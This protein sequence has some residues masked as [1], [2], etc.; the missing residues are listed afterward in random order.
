MPINFKMAVISISKFVTKGLE[1]VRGEEENDRSECVQYHPCPVANRFECPYDYETNKVSYTCIYYQINSNPDK[2]IVGTAD[3]KLVEIERRPRIVD[4]RSGLIIN[5]LITN[6]TFTVCKPVRIIK[7]QNPLS[8]LELQQRY[9]IE[10]N[11]ENQTSQLF[12]LDILSAKGL[13]L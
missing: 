11:I 13:I 5:S 6:K 7:H 9:T 1:I 3:Y 12:C 4:Q 8:F 2:Y 10:S